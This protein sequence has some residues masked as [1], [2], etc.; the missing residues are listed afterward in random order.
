MLG[1]VVLL[2]LADGPSTIVPLSAEDA[3]E[4]ARIPLDEPA[5]IAAASQ[6]DQRR[7]IENAFSVSSLRNDLI[8]PFP[9]PAPADYQERIFA[10]LRQEWELGYGL[11][12]TLSDRLNFRAQND[13]DFPN[14][15]N[16]INDLREAYVSW[17]PG[18]S[19]YLDAGRINERNGAALG[20]SPTDF[21]KTRAVIDPLTSDPAVLR[22][23]RLGTALIRAQQIWTDAALSV[24]FA[25]QLRRPSALFNDLD[26]RSLDPSLDRTNGH[27]RLLIK[28]SATL[29][30]GFSPE[31]LFY[32]EGSRTSYGANLSR[33]VGQQSV[34]Y[35]EWAGG[36]RASLTDEAL[37]F[38]R[39]TGTLPPGAP[40]FLPEDTKLH[41]QNDLSVGGSFTTDSKITLNVEYHFHEAGFSATDFDHFFA[42]GRLHN[43]LVDDEL[44]FI[45]GFAAEQQE[46]LGQQGLFLRADWPEALD[47]DLDLSGFL[48]TDLLDGSSLGQVSA[49]YALSDR[50]T[51]G[52]LLSAN[53]GGRQSDFG[54][55]PTAGTFL[56]KIARFF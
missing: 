48:N 32:R 5:P 38:G 44:A 20:F 4:L 43:A 35:A 45:R 21:F 49:D 19:L 13:I 3:D 27:D 26:L 10:D 56:F 39:A 47:P 23:D 24:A 42:L 29:D 40:S 14:R 1:L 9:P 18:P 16:L 28:G 7:F 50:W 46:P 30:D 54:S 53:L 6:P 37:E 11:T 22:E 12:A 51:I 36:R 17:Q 2:M 33:S 8:V 31:L 25:P 41:F 55:L 34:L 15:E 52:A